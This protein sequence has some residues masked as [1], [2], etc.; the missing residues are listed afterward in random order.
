MSTIK[1]R[2]FSSGINGTYFMMLDEYL[3]HDIYKY[4]FDGVM[5]QLM[6][7]TKKGQ[8]T[9]HV[10]LI[11]TSYEEIK[12][13]GYHILGRMMFWIESCQIEYMGDDKWILYGIH[14]RSKEDRFVLLNQLVDTKFIRANTRQ[15]DEMLSR[16]KV[17]K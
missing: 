5:K 12:A 13:I 7:E 15:I 4:L 10:A 2:Q 16:V 6:E 3:L 14:L 8:L 11:P 17:V 9:M 1:K